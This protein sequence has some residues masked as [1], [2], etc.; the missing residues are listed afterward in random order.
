MHG[1]AEWHKHLCMF[2]HQLVWLCRLIGRHGRRMGGQGAVAFAH[3][4]T[5]VGHELAIKFFFQEA[6]FH[7]EAGIAQVKVCSGAVVARKSGFLTTHIE[8]KCTQDQR[9][10]SVMFQACTLRRLQRWAFAFCRIPLLAI[11][12]G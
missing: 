1:I 6:A 2:F 11:P 5:N 3:E 8:V 4:K 9:S 7:R 10:A 12:C